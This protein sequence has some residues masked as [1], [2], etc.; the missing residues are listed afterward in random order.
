MNHSIHMSHMFMNYSITRNHILNNIHNRCQKIAIHMASKDLDHNR[1]RRSHGIYGIAALAATR[2]TR[3]ILIDA[4]QEVTPALCNKHQ[5]NSRVLCRIIDS[6][7]YSLRHPRNND[8]IST[9]F[10]QIVPFQHTQDA[11]LPLGRNPIWRQRPKI[12]TLKRI[13]GPRYRHLGKRMMYHCATHH[14]PQA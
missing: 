11:R 13:S 5:F 4:C 6:R 3:R 1:P 14:D 9:I 7:G 10:N 2:S 12:S 8:I